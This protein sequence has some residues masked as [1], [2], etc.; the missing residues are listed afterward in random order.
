MIIV[1]WIVLAAGFAALVYVMHAVDG[2]KA[3]RQTLYLPPGEKNPLYRG[4]DG[5]YDPKKAWIVDG[6]FYGIIVGLA[7]AFRDIEFFHIVEGLVCAGVGG[8][9][10]LRGKKDRER[11]DRNLATQKAT[12]L[13][14]QS[15]PEG[16]HVSRPSLKPFGPN[17]HVFVSGSFYDFHEETDIPLSEAGTL[18][19]PQKA[20]DARVKIK[21][22]LVNLA[23]LPE[24]EWFKVGRNLKV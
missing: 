7:I 2:Y 9:L 3:A 22:R 15:D 20:E 11:F 12:L 13:K 1:G 5:Y 24:S 16:N 4:K 6:I 10:Y 18:W 19:D 8:A 17:K 23:K 14:L 21:A